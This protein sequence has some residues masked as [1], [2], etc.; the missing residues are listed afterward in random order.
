VPIEDLEHR[1][2]FVYDRYKAI[3]NK[4]SF[5]S[6]MFS[7]VM[8]FALLWEVSGHMHD[9]ISSQAITPD[10]EWLFVR[11]RFWLLRSQ[12]EGNSWTALRNPGNIDWDKTEAG[13]PNFILSPDF[14]NDATLLF[15]LNLS[16]D[17]GETW[18][19]NL[20][21]KLT[22]RKWKGVQYET[23]ASDPISVVFSTN[24]ANDDTIFAVACEQEE[25][26][27]A[28]LLYT[29]DFGKTFL[30]VKK[31][32]AFEIGSLRPVLTATI[33][34]IYFQ[35]IVGL[36]S[37]IY[38][39]VSGSPNKWKKF[40]T[41]KNF[42][43][44]NIREDHSSGGL[45]VIDR[46]SQTLYRLNQD[47]ELIPI[48]LPSAATEKAGDQ[49]LIS[50][51]SHK[52]VGTNTSLFVLRA[53]CQNRKKRL[54]QFGVECKTLR[55]DDIDLKDY[56]LLSTDEG[57]TWKNLTIVDW[58]YQ[59]GGGE[60]LDFRNPEFT[61]VWGI[62]G[63]PTVF[64][65]TFTGLYQSDDHGES[66]EE[67]DTIST[68]ITGMNAGKIS[69][70]SAQLSVCTYDDSCWSGVIDIGQLRDGSMSRLPEGSLEK[71]MRTAL[72]A[73]PYSNIAFSDGIGFMADV[74]GV[75]RYANGFNGTY[76]EPA[77]IPFV[78]WTIP[79]IKTYKSIVHGIRFSPN[80]ENDDTMFIAGFD[81]GV[82]RSV[83]RGLTFE[84]VFNA[85]TQPQVP[86]GFDSIGVYVSP[87]FATS[88]VVFTYVTNGSRDLED[89]FLFISEDSGSNWIAIDQ[90]KNPPNLLSLAIATDNSSTG[91][92]SLVGVQMDGNAWVNRRKGDAK[93][94]GKWDP[95]RYP[96]DGAYTSVLPEKK[97]FA[98]TGYCHD[99]FLA[100]ANGKLYMSILTGGIAYGK[101]NGNRFTK[102]KSSGISQRLR[103]GGTG[104]TLV[105]NRRKTFF[106]G[107]VEIEGIFFGA[108][109]NE[110]WMSLD[111][112]K[113]WTSV[114]N[115]SPRSRR[116][117]GCEEEDKT[118]CDFVFGLT[119]LF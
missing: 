12:D 37:E 108:F 42:E 70:D 73:A 65:G 10:G 5:G 58:F 68:D 93:E 80:F 49:L 86:T 74:Y 51:Y 17:A 84:N 112:G 50:A 43:I 106:E 41:L 113:T 77:S 92:Y 48:T 66:W 38:T 117:S 107:M 87:D 61:H 3:M 47:K 34:Q 4:S 45:L 46:N 13:P 102:P 44:Q 103:F 90:G 76:S 8:A 24:F 101:L 118:L 16:T 104:Q 99:S 31:L 119:P 72:D 19:T 115:L 83:D 52:G 110:I 39:P 53:P 79:T 81:L 56:V 23:C 88:S 111:K 71:V 35:R 67:L 100:A 7:F 109:F 64:L 15:G 22:R 116:F 95:L 89:A 69:R 97:S 60:S 9:V 14:K 94:F 11:S 55:K 78:N 96:V 21:E 98:S 28:T 62:P 75:M 54:G 29:E 105:K 63:T 26:T 57:T 91:T 114:Y 1:V 85:T 30:P 40:K 6:T 32:R 18:S 36:D 33:D 2:Q 25:P 82:F 27:L 59:Q 20:E